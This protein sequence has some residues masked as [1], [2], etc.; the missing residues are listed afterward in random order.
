MKS[1]IRKEL[2]YYFTSPVGY[3]FLSAFSFVCGWF[4]VMS[5]LASLNGDLGLIF[6]NMSSAF[7]F[8][9]PILTMNIN[10]QEIKFGTDRLLYTSPVK[11]SCIMLGKFFAVLYVYS[12]ALILMLIYPVLLMKFATPDFGVFFGNIFGFFL[13]G[14]SL[15]AIG[16]FISSATKNQISSAIV[17][18]SILLVMYLFDWLSPVFRGGIS[19]FFIDFFAVS[20][21]F[22]LFSK[23]Y[24]NLA[25]VV[26]YLS[27][28]AVFVFFAVLKTKK[29]NSITVKIASFLVAI[30]FFSVNIT[31][32]YVCDNYI[33]SFD[34]T[35]NGLTELSEE[36]TDIL[37]GLKEEVQIYSFIPEGEKD[38]VLITLDE[39]LKRYKKESNRIVY[40]KI[41]AQENPEFVKKYVELGNKVSLYSV[42]FESGDKFKLVNVSDAISFNSDKALLENIMAEQFF[43]SAIVNV[44]SNE[45]I[46]VSVV[47]GHGEN[48]NRKIFADIFEI[49]NYNV[50]EINLLTDELSD[51]KMLIITTPEKDYSESE[52]EKLDDY[53]KNGGMAQIFIGPDNKKLSNLYIYLKKWGVEFSDGYVVDNKKGN[54]VQSKSYLLPEIQNTPITDAF[55]ED[56]KILMPHSRALKISDVQNVSKE[57]LLKTSENARLKKDFYST[58]ATYEEGDTDGEFILS[59]YLTKDF[60]GTKA[61]ILVVGSTSFID[62]DYVNE[63]SFVNSEFILKCASELTKNKNTVSISPKKIGNTLLNVTTSDVLKMG[64]LTVL[65]I[66]AI[67]AFLGI[68][69]RMKR[70]KL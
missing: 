65:I 70:R 29:E 57:V 7:L 26:Y 67:F 16:I 5:N 30:T 8:I 50:N 9:I 44:T 52:I 55:S 12:I 18:F 31:I 36:T 3:V 19:G 37:K 40:K 25:D 47:T 54:Y 1:I 21:R 66:P 32:D 28:T 38:K 51:S 34:L 64:L 68:F 35:K 6:S 17:T 43:T 2:Y 33:T 39:L 56:F 20:K 49:N 48:I 15:I 58:T 42:V 59:A 14:S 10:A 27:L 53:F 41:N 11:T 60:S 24:V 63:S 61:S 69:V 13:M 62:N 23:G 4:F 46:K 22:L 45:K